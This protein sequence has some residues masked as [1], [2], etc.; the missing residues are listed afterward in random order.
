MSTLKKK[1]GA[2]DPPVNKNRSDSKNVKAPSTIT[3]SKASAKGSKG[4]K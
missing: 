1:K 3:D 4:K 2:N